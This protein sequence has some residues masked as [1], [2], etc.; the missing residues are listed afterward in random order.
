VSGDG[1]Q[2]YRAALSRYAPLAIVLLALVV[3]IVAVVA[4]SGF[5]PENDSLD[6]DRHGIS[7]ADGDGYPRSGILLQGGPTALRPPGYPVFLGAV[8]AV[9][10]DSVTAGRL[11]GA[12]L[13]ALIVLLI[14]LIAKT[15]WGRRTALWAAGLAAVFP[16][17]VLLSQE[18]LS[19]SLFIALELGAVL[20]VF[21]FR[22]SGGLLRWTVLAGLLCGV[23]AITRNIGLAL[24]VPV[25]FGLWTARPRF[26]LASLAAPATMALCLVLVM[27]PWVVRN[28]VEFGRLIPI[29]SGTGFTLAGTYNPHSYAD[30]S[31]HGAWRTPQVLPEFEPW[32]KQP[33]LDEGDVDAKLRQR[34]LSFAWEHPGYVA[35]ASAWNLMRMFELSGGS[36]VGSHGEPVDQRGIGS[37]DPLSERVGLALAAILAALGVTAIVRSG[38]AAGG[39]RL[40]PRG[41]WFMWAI[42]ILAILTAAPLGGLPRYRLVADPFI[43]LL[44]GVGASWLASTIAGRRGEIA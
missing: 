23:A 8:Y 31:T 7:I 13:G 26:R 11:A 19:E 43:L 12:A 27:A 10:G 40:I 35:E 5:Q 25:A 42:P 30:G 16:P 15:V 1:V 18:L 6:Y 33:G 14:Y 37:Q 24:V 2:A 17:L 28:E 21:A 29:S 20:S 4:D 3:R 9:S 38:R 41:P 36:V 32:F 39:R 34:A 22:R 44:A